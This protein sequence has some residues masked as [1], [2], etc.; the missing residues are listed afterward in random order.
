MSKMDIQLV[1]QRGI[2]EINRAIVWDNSGDKPQD[3]FM[4]YMKGIGDLL[5]S[6]KYTKSNAIKNTVLSRVVEYMDRAEV[7][8]LKLHED[9]QDTTRISTPNPVQPTTTDQSDTIRAGVMDTRVDRASMDVKWDDV[10]GLKATKDALFEAIIWPKR[11][12]SMFIGSRQPWSAI[13]LYGPP[14]TGKSYLAKAVA[15]ESGSTFFSISSSDI[16]SKWQGESEKTIEML[17]AVANEE[18]PS[19]IFIDEIDSIAGARVDGEQES[20]RRVKTQLMMEMQGI[21]S[22]SSVVVLAA[23]NTPWTLDGAFRRRFQKRVFVGLP[24]SRARAVMFEKGL[25]SMHSTLVDTDYDTLAAMTE[26]YSGSDI[27]NVVRDS[28]M[29]PIR[30]CRDA[31]QFTLATNGGWTPVSKYPNCC[32]CPMDLSGSPSIGKTCGTCGAQCKNMYE[33]DDDT[34]VVPPV[35][36]GDVRSSVGTMHKSVAE[37]EMERYDTWTTEYGQDGS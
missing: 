11:F 32:A 10:V 14:G 13:L 31:K 3:A 12:P 24:G 5:L 34:L 30:R 36:M 18:A 25:A 8:K 6:A 20:T 27:A 19:V 26:G 22:M 9:T 2:D 29:A 37:H 1:R 16:M 28:L 4:C 21:K 35:D 17:F 23:T 33:L 7:L 15:S